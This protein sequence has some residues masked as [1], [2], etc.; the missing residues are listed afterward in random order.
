MQ[1]YHLLDYCVRQVDSG[2][3]VK[4]ENLQAGTINQNYCLSIDQ[5]KYLVKQFIGNRW[6]PT[7]RKQIFELQTHL[8]NENLAPK[9]IHLSEKKDVYI[10]QWI[11]HAP[12]QEQEKH[13]ADE[14][15][16]DTLANSLMHIH[17]SAVPCP[18]IDLPAHWQRYLKAMSD[19]QNKWRKKAQEYTQ[20]WRQY[21]QR[22]ND[23]FVLCH[24]DLQLNHV[25]SEKHIYLDWEYAATGCRFFDLIACSL[26]NQFE[27]KNANNLMALCISIFD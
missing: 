22:Y 14:H 8:S 5:R 18:S 20:L 2:I 7:D 13:A 26:A 3:V 10:E 11:E 23:D 6:L 25:V 24:N 19:P 16:V 12:A 17:S 1:F 27:Q 15:V 4:L 9:P 21:E